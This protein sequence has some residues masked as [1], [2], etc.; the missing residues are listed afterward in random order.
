M[1]LFLL[2]FSGHASTPKLR[3]SAQE[4]NTLNNHAP[5][6]EIFTWVFHHFTPEKFSLNPSKYIS[7]LSGEKSFD[8]LK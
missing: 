5:V 2:F 6:C 7:F 4:W 1:C 3:G 8:S